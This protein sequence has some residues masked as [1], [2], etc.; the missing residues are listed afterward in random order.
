MAVQRGLRDALSGVRSMA[1]FSVAICGGGIAGVEGLLRLRRLAGDQVDVTLIS[2]GEE[3]VYR[4]WTVLE[5]FTGRHAATRS[6]ESRQTPV[7]GGCVIR[8]RGWIVPGRSCTPRM[9]SG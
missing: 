7:P 8:W 9:G 1:G 4:P 2:P 6:R 3:L 5:P